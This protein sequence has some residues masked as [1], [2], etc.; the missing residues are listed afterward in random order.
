MRMPADI[1]KKIIAVKRD[2]VAALHRG[3]TRAQLIDQG[4]TAGVP[5]GFRKAI[6]AK[7]T[8]TG[9]A[10]LIAEVKKASPS[11]GIIRADFD[12]VWIAQKYEAG[13]AACL[14]V[15][16][17]R[18]FFQGDLAFLRQIRERVKLPLLRKDFII[19]SLQLYE[20]RA[21]GADAVLL[22]AACL[23]SQQLQ[24]LH[25]EATSIGLD[26]L[27]EV[28]DEQEWEGILAA[29]DAPPLAGV[30]NRNL[31]DFSVTLE[32]TEHLAPLITASG[33]AL[34]AESGIFT[35]QHVERLRK[36][37]ASAVLVGESLM[38]EDDPGAAARRLMS[39]DWQR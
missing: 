34:V 7:A 29:G 32:T 15:L 3:C 27:V 28:H 39:V 22:I 11:K 17:D 9:N 6:I 2:E 36:C 23:S 19:D 10:A 18:Q 16:T 26:V 14:S 1:L 30:N 35:P 8:A 31:R 25:G 4:T 38:R 24:E 21:A 13:G 33:T 12:P 37:G 20:A 5:R